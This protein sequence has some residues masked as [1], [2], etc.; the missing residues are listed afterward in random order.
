MSAADQLVEAVQSCISA[1]IAEFDISRQQDFL[2]AASYGKTFCLNLDPAEFVES[3]KK[4]RLLNDVR[5]PEIGIPLTVQQFNRL[6]PESLVGR[7]TQRGFHYLALRMCQHLNLRCE[8]KVLVHW[9]CGKIRK[10]ASKNESDESIARAIRSKLEGRSRVSYLE[11]ASTA[12]QMGK[13]KLAT[14]L[15][16]LEQNPADQVP[17]LL[18]MHEEELAL[19][20]AISS[21]D[22]DLLHIALLHLERSRRDDESS[23]YKLVLSYPEASN[24]LK[25]YYRNKITPADRSLFHN[26]MLHSKNYLEA[27]IAAYNQYSIEPDFAKK[28]QLARESINLFAQGKGELSFIKAMAEENSELMELQKA[29]EVRTGRTDFVGISVSETLTALTILSIDNQVEFSKWNSEINKIAKKFKVPD[30]IV[31]STKIKCYS[32]S[33]QWTMLWKLANERKPVVGYKP[34]AMACVKHNQSENEV[35]KYVDKI[36]SS[37]ERYDLYAELKLWQRAGEIAVKM[38]D[39]NR[40]CQV[41]K[42]ATVIIVLLYAFLAL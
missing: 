29:L 36:S 12:H 16:D 38:K 41:T 9:A 3:A 20:K 5:R 24:L 33:G 10:M 23:F 32:E 15:L 26:F 8:D 21:G 17:L 35:S 4:L 11:I 39:E 31:L 34:F 40:M 28:A 42:N 25:V 37:E 27:G 22:T 2:R 6:T 7:L 19:Q 30:K 1:A 14:A 18:S 13:R